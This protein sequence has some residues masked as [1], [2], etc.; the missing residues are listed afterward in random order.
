[1]S[2]GIREVTVTAGKGP[3]YGKLIVVND[4][5]ANSSLSKSHEVFSGQTIGRAAASGCQPNSVHVTVKEKSSSGEYLPVDPTPY[6]DRI[7]LP[8]LK[9]NQVCDEYKLVLLGL[10]L[11]SG[12]LS[13]AAK[14]A[15]S[16]ISRGKNPFQGVGDK[17][18]DA[19]AKTKKKVTEAVDKTKKDLNEVKEEVQRAVGD[20]KD[21]FSSDGVKD[22]FK[23]VFPSPG[24]DIPEYEGPE[25]GASASNG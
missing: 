23:E 10:T 24:L 18:K 16:D 1:M 15:V 4:I 19:V 2:T 21:A 5:V 22:A 3:F 13:E 25:F 9:W 11:S 12:R 6:L 7:E 20:I 8:E 14:Q 17:V